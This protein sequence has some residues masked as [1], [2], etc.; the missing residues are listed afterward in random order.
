MTLV[1][2]RQFI[3][4][5]R[6]GSFVKA[7]GMLH[8]TQPALSRSIKALEEELGQLL[9]D[10]VGKKIELTSF[11]EATRQRCESLVENAEAIRK[12][13]RP[14][15]AGHAGRL[16]L[17]LGSGPGAMLTTSILTNVANQHPNMRVD[18]YRANTEA[19][20]RMLRERE[21]DALVVDIR[22]LKPAPDLKVDQVVEVEGGFMCRKGH[23]LARLSKVSFDQLLQY[24]IASTPLSDELARILIERYGER[25]HPEVMVKLMSDEISHLVQVAQQ[26]DTVLLAIRPAAPQLSWLKVTPTLSA[27]ARFGMVTM[28]NKAEALFL[29]QVRQLMVQRFQ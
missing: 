25:A 7:A 21:V 13:G 5:A 12:S 11:G 16:R 29:P 22:S 18:I 1:Q 17:G 3:T 14:T 26:S 9:F 8:I 15:D 19:L 6:T 24:P 23:P 2:L 4:L 10:R 28:A 20:V 27:R